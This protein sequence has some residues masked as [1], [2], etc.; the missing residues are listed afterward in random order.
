MTDPNDKNQP[1]TASPEAGNAPEPNSK[2]IQTKPSS[3]EVVTAATLPTLVS[4]VVPLIFFGL[5]QNR[6]V[7][8]GVGFPASLGLVVLGMGSFIGGLYMLLST[9][10][11]FAREGKGSPGSW[12][13]PRELITTGPYSFVRNPLISGILGT[14]FGETLLFGSIFVLMWFVLIWVVN[15]LYFPIAE[16]P[17]LHQRFGRNYKDYKRNVP[18]WIPR[19][20]PWKRPKNPPPPSADDV[21]IDGEKKDHK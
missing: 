6:E 12:N 10:A 3:G 21:L 16:E 20:R 7:F 4:I 5:D 17:A 15:S 19:L 8:W 2:F 14:L 11:L 1:H 13:P 9:L 18:R